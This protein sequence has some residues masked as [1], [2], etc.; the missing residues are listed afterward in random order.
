[1]LLNPLRHV[2]HGSSGETNLNV[3]VSRVGAR[4]A[5]F[6]TGGVR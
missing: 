4:L 1:M 3:R 5:G 6:D 2:G